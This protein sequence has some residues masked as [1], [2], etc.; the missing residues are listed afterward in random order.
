MSF[1]N[2]SDQNLGWVLGFTLA[3]AV[4]LA[5]ISWLAWNAGVA[6]PLLILALFVGSMA[7]ALLRASDAINRLSRFA[8]FAGFVFMTAAAFFAKG[9]E[10][11]HEACEEWSENPNCAYYERGRAC[12][13]GQTGV[14][15]CIGPTP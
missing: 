13:V 5:V 11:Q 6:F 3:Y 4:A 14:L 8:L 10:E 15:R 9:V 2:K 12:S 1:I 7:T